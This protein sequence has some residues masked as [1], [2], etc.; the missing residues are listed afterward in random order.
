MDPH[1]P[2]HQLEGRRREGT[3]PELATATVAGAGAGGRSACVA[4]EAT[5]SIH[6][7]G[8]VEFIM[9]S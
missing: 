8:G 9:V 5:Q 4:W 6:E 7:L 2:C 3:G 1:S